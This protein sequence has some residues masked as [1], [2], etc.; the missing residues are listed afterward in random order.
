MNI[1][2]AYR[3]AGPLWDAAELAAVKDLTISL[4]ARLICDRRNA[5]HAVDLIVLWSFSRWRRGPAEIYIDTVREIALKKPLT[6]LFP[7]LTFMCTN[8]L[9]RLAGF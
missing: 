2:G 8:L 5:V 1:L 7:Q 4:R 9:F 3:L 6:P